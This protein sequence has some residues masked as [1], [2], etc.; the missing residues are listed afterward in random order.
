M[1]RPDCNR[2]SIGQRGTEHI[3][4]ESAHELV[5]RNGRA[6]ERRRAGGYAGEPEESSNWNWQYLPRHAG[7]VLAIL[8]SVVFAAQSATV[9]G[10]LQDLTSRPFGGQLQF[11]PV[12]GAQSIGT[13]TYFP[14]TARCAVSNGLFAINLV[15]GV[16]LA[17]PVQYNAFGP[18]LAG[19]G[20]YVP[21]G[22][23]N[24]WQFNDCV[25]LL[26][27]TVVVAYTNT[28][29]P[30]TNADNASINNDNG[31]NVTI[32]TPDNFTVT[33]S[34]IDA[35][36][37]LV[38]PPS[39]LNLT[40]N[41]PVVYVDF[42]TGYDT[43]SGAN[44][45]QPFKTLYP[46]VAVP[47]VQTIVLGPGNQFTTNNVS[48]P[49]GISVKGAGAGI[50]FLIN[51]NSPANTAIQISDKDIFQDI[52]CPG[53]LGFNTITNWVVV[54]RVESATSAN[55]TAVDSIIFGQ[56]MPG[57]Q[58]WLMDMWLRSS[59]DVQNF[60]SG[61]G[62]TF[63]LVNVRED[64]LDIGN[65]TTVHGYRFRGTNTVVNIY[66]GSCVLSNGFTSVIAQFNGALSNSV[67]IADAI[68]G[69]SNITFNVYGLSI[70]TNQAN[71]CMLFNDMTG[72]SHLNLFPPL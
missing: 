29:A 50:T 49:P 11:T 42:N 8:F 44:V 62:A 57:A 48:L 69:S 3:R 9:I 59:Y 71:A 61:T 67:F 17:A 53:Q 56:M 72:T 21:F 1:N 32:V 20:L 23:T 40:T 65:Q 58:I 41:S 70:N 36:I 12:A 66:G 5:E 26:A 18:R 15:G 52:S 27:S 2:L 33:R 34:N 6:I 25:R 10:S 24:I 43:N 19:Q 4:W 28:G 51:S 16:Y 30:V 45:A 47:G 54:R 7:L 46:A 38:T 35:E 22:D 14:V 13:N 39:G 31:T 60:N 55:L 68:G 37:E 63:N 64:V